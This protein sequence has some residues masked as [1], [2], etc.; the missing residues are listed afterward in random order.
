MGTIFSWIF[1]NFNSDIKRITFY[2]SGAQA[3]GPWGHMSGIDLTIGQNKPHPPGFGPWAWHCPLLPKHSRIRSGAWHCPL[4][5]LCSGIG[6]QGSDTVSFYS[7][8]PGLGHRNLVLPPPSLIGPWTGLHA[9]LALH[10]GSG[11]W[12][13][14]HLDP[15]HWD[16]GSPASGIFPAGEWYHHFLTAKFPDPGGMPWRGWHGTVGQNRSTGQGY[17]TPI[18]HSYPSNYIHRKS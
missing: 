8:A 12:I 18:W 16:L 2:T 17:I 3:F 7:C 13:C 10:I 6:P 11:P 4:W 5:S 1:L 15:T 14:L 9:L